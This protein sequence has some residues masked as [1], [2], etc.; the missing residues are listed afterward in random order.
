MLPWRSRGRAP[1]EVAAQAP[2]ALLVS[3][4]VHNLADLVAGDAAFAQP[5]PRG[6]ATT[7]SWP[8]RPPGAVLGSDAAEVAARQEVSAVEDVPGGGVL[9]IAKPGRV[10]AADSAAL[11]ETASWL[12]LAVR[13]DQA[14]AARDQ[15]ARRAAGLESDLSAARERL[16]QVRD[17]ERRRLV[18]S[19][20]A[21]TTR[22]FADVRAR[23]TGLRAAFATGG[24]AGAH[25]AARAVAGLRDALDEL[26]DTFR[27]VVRDVHPAMLPERGPQAALEELAAT[28]P[29]P[30]R[31]TGSF[32]RRVGWEVES[33]LYHAASAVLALLAGTRTAEPVAVDLARTDGVL[34]MVAT[35]TEP[36]RGTADL[37]AALA[38]DTERLAVLGGALTCAVTEGT[39]VVTVL[40]PERLGP[41]PVVADTR[42][43]LLDDLRDLLAQGWQGAPDEPTRARWATIADR[44]GRPVRLAVV[45]LARTSVVGA[46]LGVEVRSADRP[47]WYAH[48]EPGATTD[49]EGRA[50]VRLSGDFVNGMTVVD[51]PGLVGPALAERLVAPVQGSA[52]A[53]D[54]VLCTSRPEPGFRSTLRASEHRVAVL[55]TGPALRPG[56]ALV[57]ATLHE[58]EYRA[59]RLADPMGL[60]RI[61]VADRPTATEAAAGV[62]E[63]DPAALAAAL[64]DHSGLSALRRTIAD[65][66]TARAEVIA[67]RR[68]LHAIA[69]LVRALPPEDPVRWHAERVR[70]EAHDVAELDLLDDLDRGAF[71]NPAHRAEALRLLGTR[72]TD[73]RTRLGLPPST[74]DAQV[75]AAAAEAA[76][77]WRTLAEH[78]ASTAR[79]RRAC[80]TLI[81]TCE[82]IA[83]PPT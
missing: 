29:R 18:G 69:D 15:A 81:R 20:T 62:A 23:A 80:E 49:A 7:A 78:P 66:V 67:A 12:G 40:L 59:L 74:P 30:V 55:E 71:P 17:L 41:P 43:G 5:G 46:L 57:A 6:L 42:A 14:R 60:G 31:F 53:V 32:G 13:L 58:D 27:A 22:D 24:E 75:R 54:A 37:A 19:I 44:L 51:V 79:T 28:L 61:P 68:A 10:S 26:I 36:A 73:P 8:A 25:D 76:G 16:A 11:R 64:A 70:V 38:D 1:H 63:Q 50:V 48:G 83:A 34:R 39:A 33:G 2:A 52:P 56:L 9:L 72:G 3:A 45:G 4:L 21:V 82:G 65:E 47:V 35:A 77:R